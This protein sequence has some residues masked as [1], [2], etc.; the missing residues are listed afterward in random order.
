[1]GILKSQSEFLTY[2]SADQGMLVAIRKADQPKI[3]K[4]WKSKDKSKVESM[5]AGFPFVQTEEQETLKVDF[6]EELQFEI[7]HL[8]KFD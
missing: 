4:Y 2:E 3:K 7:E 5:I 1:M 6:S 8:K